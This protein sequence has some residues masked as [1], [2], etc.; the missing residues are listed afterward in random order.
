MLEYGF[1]IEYLLL[2]LLKIQLKLINLSKNEKKM[3]IKT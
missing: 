3:N 2:T 1:P